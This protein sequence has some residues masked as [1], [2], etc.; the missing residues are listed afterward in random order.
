VKNLAEAVEKVLRR[1]RAEL[2]RGPEAKDVAKV[3]LPEESLQSL[4]TSNGQPYSAH[5]TERHERY[6]QVMALH[7]QGM[8]IKEI[9]KRVGMGQRTI[10]SWFAHDEYP[11]TCYH[12]RRHRSRF[13]A[14][15]P[16]VQQRW[17]QGCHNIQQIWPRASKH[18][19][20]LIPIVRCEPIS[21]HFVARGKLHSR[22][23]L[24]W[25][26]FPQKRRPGSFSVLSRI[27]MRE[28]NKHW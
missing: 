20:I 19:A 4:L 23:P 22:K 7:Q 9:A 12:T 28:N 3:E 25:S 8:K 24:L 1:Y 26:V 5:Q 17:D 21:N 6:Q 14:Y 11:E 2:S 18:R 16:Y 15:A 10:Q 13:D 27:S